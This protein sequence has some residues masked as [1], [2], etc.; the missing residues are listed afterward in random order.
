MRHNLLVLLGTT[1][2]LFE[3]NS[4]R[5][6]E[7]L[8]TEIQPFSLKPEA[9]WF[10]FSVQSDTPVDITQWS[11][12][13]NRGTTKKI[14]DNLSS[15]EIPVLS[16]S[17][18]VSNFIAP[19]PVYFSWT[20][21]PISLSDSG[22]QITITNF[23]NQ[24]LATIQYPQGKKGTISGNPYSDI[25]NLSKDIMRLLPLRYEPQ[26]NTQF[27]S[28]KGA[29][30]HRVPTPADQV[31]VLISEISPLRTNQTDGDFVELWVKEGPSIINLKYLELKYNGTRIYKFNHDFLV[32]PDT[33]LVFYVGKN[34]TGPINQSA[35]YEFYSQAIAGISSG[36]GSFELLLYSGTSAEIT[37]DYV[38]TQNQILSQTEQN[39]L[40]KNSNHWKSPC[41][42]LSNIIIN[43]SVARAPGGQDTDTSYD[44]F[45]HFNGSPGHINTTTNNKPIAAIEIQG[46]GKKQ[47]NGPFSVN[48]T[49]E[50]STDPDGQQDLKLY[51]WKLN[52]VVFST[53]QNPVSFRLEAI[54][55]YRVELT[56]EDYSGDTDTTT[57]I[58][59]VLPQGHSRQSASNPQEAK[60]LLSAILGSKEAINADGFFSDLL[61]QA[62]ESFWQ[63]ITK[64]EPPISSFQSPNE[65][66]TILKA[67]NKNPPIAK[68]LGMIF[69]P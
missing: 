58:F 25:F 64:P 65:S 57:A 28:T 15:L 30:N 43:Q 52:D 27:P 56:I 50:P 60:A 24:P 46:T 33:R 12:K 9:E 41:I 68:N 36:S 61:A 38:C 62:P 3:L 35:P 26:N 13:N 48:L 45:S 19:E 21:S 55:E 31:E 16:G 11:I 10:E 23:L 49:G 1:Y 7:V 5:A 4:A 40:D 17:G 34:F 22:D 14:G 32:G 69:Q 8:I 66:P 29:L 53:A 59:S 18:F 63:D 37:E 42:E 20:K 54:G 6:L 2:L 67:K 39:R 47:N 51:T 44:F